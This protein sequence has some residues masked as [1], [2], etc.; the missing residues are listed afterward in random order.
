MNQKFALS[1]EAELAKRPR[2]NSVV[3]RQKKWWHLMYICRG[4]TKERQ[5]NTKTLCLLCP[6]D[7]ES[8]IYRWQGELKCKLTH[9]QNMFQQ[10]YLFYYFI[11]IFII[12]LKTYIITKKKQHFWN[13]IFPFLLKY[14]TVI[15]H[16]AI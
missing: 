7:F 3:A 14:F 5:Q 4:D 2:F 12:M 9:G 6:L 13:I 8:A 11:Y 10:I 16:M 1:K 15:S